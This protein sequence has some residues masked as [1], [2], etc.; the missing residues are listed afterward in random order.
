MRRNPNE[1]GGPCL[2]TV[3]VLLYWT[4]SFQIRFQPAH[5]N[6]QEK[7][8]YFFVQTQL[9]TLIRH[10]KV[11]HVRLTSIPRVKTIN[12]FTTHSIQIFH[13]PSTHQNPFCSVSHIF[14]CREADEVRPA[15]AVPLSSSWNLLSERSSDK[16]Y[17]RLALNVTP[18]PSHAATDPSSATSLRSASAAAATRIG[19][20]GSSVS[21][22]AKG[23]APRARPRVQDQLRYF[24][25]SVSHSSGLRSRGSI[26]LQWALSCIR[27]LNFDCFGGRRG[28]DLTAGC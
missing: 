9:K 23:T 1:C 3:P 26:A 20:N 25:G 22:S 28:G 19:V 10:T 27:Y 4:R 8:K 24:S 6:R 15:P 11:K 13:H 21:L 14:F 18:S 7:R 2:S 17:H 12:V 5:P 16:H